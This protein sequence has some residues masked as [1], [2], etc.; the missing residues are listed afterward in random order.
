[1]EKHIYGNLNEGLEIIERNSSYF[2]RYDAGAHQEAWRE[3]KIS[4]EEALKIQ[5]GHKEENETLFAL[6]KRLEKNGVNPF[7]SNWNRS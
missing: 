1:M 6:Q 4:E 2:V 7:I 3:D 5:K